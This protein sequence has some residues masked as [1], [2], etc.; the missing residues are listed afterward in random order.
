MGITVADIS[1]VF[2]EGRVGSG[3]DPVFVSVKNGTCVEIEAMLV[4][5]L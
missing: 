3:S 1:G 2:T 5:L 4:E